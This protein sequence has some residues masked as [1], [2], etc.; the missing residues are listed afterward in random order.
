VNHTLTSPYILHAVKWYAQQ[1]ADAGD[2]A[3][4]T[5]QAIKRYTLG[6]KERILLAALRWVAAGNQ[7]DGWQARMALSIAG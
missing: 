2:F 5:I 7:D 3:K 4:R 1:N 6:D